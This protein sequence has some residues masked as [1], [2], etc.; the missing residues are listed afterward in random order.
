[1]QISGVLRSVDEPIIPFFNGIVGH[2]PRFD[3]LV[4]ALH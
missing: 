2:D 1:M 4:A 3:D